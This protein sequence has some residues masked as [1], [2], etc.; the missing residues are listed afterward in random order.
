[1]CRGCSLGMARAVSMGLIVFG[2]MRACT[3]DGIGGPQSRR[4]WRL[5]QRS[6][7]W[8]VRRERMSPHASTLL[9]TEMLCGGSGRQWQESGLV[10][11]RNT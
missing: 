6:S 2:G 3:H 4:D 10:G 8:R 11:R 7:T 9:S 1:M 5:R